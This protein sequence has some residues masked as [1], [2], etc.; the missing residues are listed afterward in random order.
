VCVCVWVPMCKGAVCACVWGG[1]GGGVHTSAHACACM[2]ARVYAWLCVCESV[3]GE[4]RVCVHGE[5]CA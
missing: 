5:F 1:G 3:G 4:G 2:H